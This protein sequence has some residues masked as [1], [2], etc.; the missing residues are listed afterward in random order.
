MK[1]VLGLFEAHLPVS[2]VDAAIAFYR[3]HVGLSLAHVTPGRHAA[4]FWTGAAGAS[5]IGLWHAGASPHRMTLHIAFR[6]SRDAV[7]GSPATLR[8]AGITPLDF[9]GR[10]TDQP[11]VLAWMPAVAVYFRDPDGHLL[12][13]LAM[14]DEPARPEQGV[15]S[16]TAWQAP[17]PRSSSECR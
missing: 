9:D 12:E 6:M 5:M 16:W 8:A 3:D 2:D 13:Y 11:V 4:F 7:V 17:V 1:Q 15:V 10:P 14:L